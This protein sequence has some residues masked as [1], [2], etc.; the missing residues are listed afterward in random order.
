MKTMAFTAPV[1]RR[2]AALVALPVLCALF[3]APAL[4]GVSASLDRTEAT[5][6]ETVTLILETDDPSQQLQTDLSGLEGDFA[7]LNQSTESRVSLV[8]GQRSVVVRLLIR[9]EPLRAGTLQIPPLSFAGASTSSIALEVREPPPL[10]PGE[11]PPVIVEVALD[12]PEGP[13]YVMSQIGLTLRIMYK[14]NLTDA[15][16]TSPAPDQA[17]LRQIDETNYQVRRGGEVYDVIDKRFALFPE[18]SGTMEIPPVVLT[19]R[20]RSLASGQRWSPTDRGRRIRASSEPLSVEVLPRPDAYTGTHW[21]PARELELSQRISDIDDLKAGEPLTVTLIVDAVGLEENMLEEPAWPDLEGARIYA[22][23]PQGITRDDGEWVLGHKEFRYAVVPEQAGELRLPEIRLDWWDTVE[24]RQRTAVVP[25]QTFTVAPAA[26]T[27]SAMP[28]PAEAVAAERPLPPRAAGDLTA[29]NAWRNA[30]LVF[31]GL[32]LGTLVLWLLRRGAP[33]A[34]SPTPRDSGDERAVLQALERACRDGDA[35]AARGALA[36]W[37]RHHGPAEARGSVL[38]FARQGGDDAL[39]DAV[40]A[41]EAGA[42][43][44]GQETVDTQALWRAFQAWRKEGRRRPARDDGA[45]RSLE[46]YADGGGRRA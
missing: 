1:L 16:M 2:I 43:A 39:R 15:G 24:N 35:A 25:P 44:P 11:Q 46:L 32:W 9:L 8:N 38:A 6:G 23:Q 19:G 37:V 18:R 29:V 4:A 5:L 17:S 22:D 3:A 21:L 30:A 26:S 41:L 10:A 34:P 12:P 33:R 27:A 28:P 42:F 36:R 20:Y 13:Y 14:R 40:Y 31:A 7:V 45:E